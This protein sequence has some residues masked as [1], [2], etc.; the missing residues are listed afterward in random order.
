MSIRLKIGA[1]RKEGTDNY[2]SIGASCEVEGVEIP[3]GATPEQILEIRDYWFGLCEMSVTQQLAVLR[4]QQPG[5]APAANGHA[6]PPPARPAAPAPAAPAR[7]R[8]T[9][10]TADHGEAARERPRGGGGGGKDGPPRSGKALYARLKD[11]DEA[12]DSLG[13]VKW[14][15]RWGKSRGNDGRITQWSDEEAAAGWTAAQRHMEALAR[16]ESLQSADY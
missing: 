5:A 15:Q 2:G 14:A 4:G 3:A 16:S 6:A 11:L 9:W 13:L 7:E 10:Q 1:Q 8:Q 12:D